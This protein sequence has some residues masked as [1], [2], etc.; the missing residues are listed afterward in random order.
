MGAVVKY[1]AEL[2]PEGVRAT[3]NKG[4]TALMLAASLGMRRL[5][6]TWQSWIQKQPAGLPWRVPCDVINCMFLSLGTKAD[7]K[8]IL[9]YDAPDMKP[10][11][12][13]VIRAFQYVHK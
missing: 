10:I 2:G 3:D 5:C 6:S 8:Q 12:H 4:W 11:I 9:G 1:L 7:T 13:A